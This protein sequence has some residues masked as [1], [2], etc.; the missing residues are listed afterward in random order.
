MPSII[1]SYYLLRYLNISEGN[2]LAVFIQSPPSV[3][4]LLIS[5]TL[6][7]KYHDFNKKNK[8]INK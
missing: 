7:R 3:I 8:N 6:L 2:I 5:V 1:I 4:I